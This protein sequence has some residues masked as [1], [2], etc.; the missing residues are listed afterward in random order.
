MLVDEVGNAQFA[1]GIQSQY[2]EFQNAEE[3]IR[4]HQPDPALRRALLSPVDEEA[5]ADLDQ[6]DAEALFELQEGEKLV[7][8]HVHGNALVGA[9]DTNGRLSKV[10]TGAND[11]YESALTPE[12]AATK[13]QADYDVALQKEAAKLR[14]DMELKLAETQAD[15]QAENAEAMEKIRSDAADALAKALEEA[16][17]AP[18]EEAAAPKAEAKSTSKAKS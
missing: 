16:G 2:G 8:Y 6:E 7:S 18:A 1:A 17:V 14:Q 9:I 4:A 11:N 12:E 15:L 5:T 13:A 10:V 3:L